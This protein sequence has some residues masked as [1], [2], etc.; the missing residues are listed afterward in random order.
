[1][2]GCLTLNASASTITVDRVQVRACRAETSVAGVRAS[3]LNAGSTIRLTNLVVRDTYSGGQENTGLA[4]DAFAAADATVTIANSTILDAAGDVP[5]RPA[6]QLIPAFLASTIE[7]TNKVVLSMHD[8]TPDIGI[9]SYVQRATLVRNHYDTLT[10][11]F[12]NDVKS[13]QRSE[14]D[15]DLAAN[16]APQPTSLLYDTGAPSP[17]AGAM[18][19]YGNPR[20]VGGV[21][22]VGAVEA[23]SDVVFASSF[24]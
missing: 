4:I 2:A 1:M 23:P 5:T 13:T 17:L 8:G 7:V 15:P 19:V 10:A 12:P 9:G 14:G 21:I 3:A 22:D 6:M 18:D 11:S 24:E 20:V 16:L